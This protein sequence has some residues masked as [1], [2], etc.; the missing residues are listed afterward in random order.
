M[1]VLTRDMGQGGTLPGVRTVAEQKKDGDLV[2]LVHVQAS[3]RWTV[4]STRLGT[5]GAHNLSR[6]AHDNWDKLRWSSE[7][8]ARST[9]VAPAGVRLDSM[10]AHKRRRLRGGA[11]QAATGSS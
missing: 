3:A 7:V 9:A 1:R 2:R 6:R 10:V 11:E 5:A 8:R 4:L